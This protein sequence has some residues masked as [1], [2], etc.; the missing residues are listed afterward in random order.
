MP[1]LI[2]DLQLEFASITKQLTRDFPELKI[3]R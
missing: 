1:R 2:H 3:G